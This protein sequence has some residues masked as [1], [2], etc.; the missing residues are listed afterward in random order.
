[1]LAYT[2]IQNDTAKMHV[3]YLYNIKLS[4][5]YNEAHMQL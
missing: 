2:R 3:K 1:M 4:Y 5:V